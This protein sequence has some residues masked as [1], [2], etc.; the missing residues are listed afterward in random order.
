MQAGKQII[1][2]NFIPNLQL[3]YKIPSTATIQ[4][5]STSN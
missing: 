2:N 5:R 1:K 4:F 3:H